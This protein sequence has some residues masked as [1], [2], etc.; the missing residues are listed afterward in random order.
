LQS[1]GF[2][3]NELRNIVRAVARTLPKTQDPGLL[4]ENN[5]ITR[6][7]IM[8]EGK[9]AINENGKDISNKGLSMNTENRVPYYTMLYNELMKRNLIK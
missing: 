3:Q 1:I 6:P 5:T 8:N 2:K 7:Y 4:Q 9:Q